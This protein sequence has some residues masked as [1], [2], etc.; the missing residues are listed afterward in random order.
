MVRA[1]SREDQPEQLPRRPLPHVCVCVC[2]RVCSVR[3]YVRAAVDVGSP[4]CAV[5]AV[6]AVRAVPPVR[7]C[8][9]VRMCAVRVG[10]SACVC[11]QVS[12][13]CVPVNCVQCGDSVTAAV[14]Y[15]AFQ[16]N[17]LDPQPWAPWPYK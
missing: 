9:R 1:H 6:R 2:V 11:K 7:V 10:A 17:N 12:V 3:V 4:C 16:N 8:L 5:R 15:T 14:D 13:I